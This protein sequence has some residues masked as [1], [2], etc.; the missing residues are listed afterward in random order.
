LNP[1]DTRAT[2]RAEMHVRFG[3]APEHVRL[4]WAPY[5]I[6]PLGAHI[7]HQLGTVT[8]TAIDRGVHL[9]FAPSGS[10]EARLASLAFPGEVRFRVDQIPPKQAGDWGNYPRGAAWA[11]GRKAPLRQGL[12]GLTSGDLAE[13]GLSS[14]A[15][16]GLACLLALEEVNG[17]SCLPVEN[18]RLDQAIE[19]EYLGLQNGILDQAAILCSRRGHLTVIDCRAF[20]DDARADQAIRTVPPSPALPPVAILIAFS[21]LTQA[22]LS[23]DY[24]RRVAE[25]AAAAR[26]LL[27]AAGRPLAP[28]RLGL[29]TA[30]EFQAHRFLLTGAS[31]RRA[32]H[33]FSEMDRVQ[34][35]LDAWQR[36]ELVLLGRLMRESG[37]SSIRN[38]ECGC[39]ALIDLCDLLNNTPG[40]YGARFSGAGFRGCCVAL[41]EP[42]AAAALLPDLALRYAACQPALANRAQFFLCESADGARL[43]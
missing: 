36:G 41:A 19:N 23:T 13:V 30:D 27:Q 35:G 16:I 24:N 5:R 42:E 28:A 32:E 21:G 1:Q 10:A 11:L 39:P 15:A 26:V 9:A 22:V 43:L 38:Y 17:L 7:D 12:V 6:C 29:V 37:H 14:S 40:V 33:F 31:A 3:I 34:R 20:A 2:L 25:C 4:V 18:I 8:A